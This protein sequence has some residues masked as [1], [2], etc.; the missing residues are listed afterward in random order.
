[1]TRTANTVCAL[2]GCQ[3]TVWR[4]PDGSYSEFCSRSHRS[5]AVLRS[6][7]QVCKNCNIRPVYVANGQALPFCGNRC[8]T[9]WKTGGSSSVPRDDT[10][11]E[12]SSEVC[13]LAGCSRPTFVDRNGGPSEYCSQ[14]HRREAVGNGE[15]EAC[16]MC[17]EWP[18]TLVAGKRSDFCSLRCSQAVFNTAPAILELDGEDADR[19][20]VHQQFTSKWAHTTMVP[21]IWKIFAAKDIYDTIDRYKLEVERRTGLEGGN[22]LRRWHGTVRTCRLG[23][24]EDKHSFC[25]DPACSL[26][27]I[28]QTSFKKA[29]YGQRTNFG[30]FG[31][32]IYTSATSSKANDYVAQVSPS[33]Y[34]AMLLND[35]V[36]GKTK[37]LTTSDPNLTKPPNGYD[38]VVGE[39]GGDLNYDE[40]IVY[41]NDAIRPIFLV[42][43][44]P[45]ATHL[46]GN[47]AAGV[48]RNGPGSVMAPFP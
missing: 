9:A 40:C 26:C 43:Y 1:M 14:R 5:A 21:S 39:P 3:K 42:I 28:I 32:G 4:D 35:V 41:R 6:S 15:A 38:S 29:N 34:R 24:E 8:A 10:D 12:A 22:S 20:S 18:R 16:L 37:K 45:Q 2:P 47:P 46:G 30:R 33:P 44:D 7:S 36:L 19:Q 48:P 17:R 27:L 23:D 11:E 25:S 13:A 31:Q